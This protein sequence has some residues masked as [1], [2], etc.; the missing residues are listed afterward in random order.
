MKNINKGLGYLAIAGIAIVTILVTK[1]LSGDI[2][3]L[4]LILFILIILAD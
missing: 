4:V 1:E 2:L 3:G